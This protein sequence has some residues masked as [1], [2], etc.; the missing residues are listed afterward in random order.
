MDADVTDSA[1]TPAAPDPE[2]PEEAAR[3]GGPEAA[4]TAA[5]ARRR[6]RRRLRWAAFAL[7][8][9]VLVGA[10]IA[11]AAYRKLDGNIATDTSA[12]AE[13]KR[14]EKERPSQAVRG[15]MNLLLIGS[16]TREGAGNDRY[17]RRG[18]GQRSDT[19]ILL[20][21]SADRKRGTAVSLPRDLMVDIPSCRSAD[22]SS[23]Q[24]RFGQFNSAY[25]AGGTACTVRTVEKLTGI[26]IDHHVVVD[27]TGFKRMVDAV[28]GVQVCLPRAID[29][30]D[31]DLRLP[32]G[33]QT[34]DGE[35][36][37]G[38]VR[39]RKTLG[40]GSDTERM[41][42]QQDFLASLVK[43][44]QSNGVLLNPTR[45]YPLLDAATSA[46]TTDPGLDSLRDLYDL[47]RS[48]RSIPSD[49]LQF[50]TVPRRSYVYD[51]NRDEL[52]QP[53]ADRLFAQLRTDAPVTVTPDASGTPSA[54]PSD[55][56]AAVGPEGEP[57]QAGAPDRPAAPSPDA[58]ASGAM[59]G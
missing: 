26:R 1:G 7:A 48:L 12:A 4:G 17:G 35:E 15:A 10:G 50:L 9:V 42:R 29:D 44:V 40:N 22:G 37:L 30:A 19:T 41:E 27:F 47:T 23:T 5:P 32:A 31:A 55:S 45:L 20:H 39:A 59:C 25:T 14:W 3:A 33:R 51:A 34:L 57:G 46:V 28:G 13:L 8:V 43:K 6:R 24:E 58:S 53:D 52:V 11:W 38:Y 56:P 54:D 18:K 49:K 16:D 21:L 2:D 36:A